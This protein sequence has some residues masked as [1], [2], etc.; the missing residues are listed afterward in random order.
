M[1]EPVL[2]RQRTTDMSPEE[3]VRFAQE[4]NAGTGL[5]LS[6][7]ERAAIDAGRLSDEALEKYQGGDAGSAEN[8]DFVRSFMRSVPEPGEEGS[9]ASA[10]GQ[11]SLDGAQ[12]VRNALLHAAYGDSN[13]V[14][15]LAEKISNRSGAFSAIQPAA[16]RNFAAISSRGPFIPAP[17]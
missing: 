1:K 6:P 2:V 13:L 16:S 10:N 12:R 5:A 11:L 7:S 9:F 3:R 15:S 4:A 14:S 8:R 17:I